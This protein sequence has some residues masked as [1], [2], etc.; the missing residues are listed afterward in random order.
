M[1]FVRTN[2][3]RIGRLD[4]EYGQCPSVQYVLRHGADG[5]GTPVSSTHYPADIIEHIDPLEMMQRDTLHN[6][7]NWTPWNLSDAVCY[8]NCLRCPN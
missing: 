8:W 4:G 7:G 1:K 3:G 6:V 2:R 5:D